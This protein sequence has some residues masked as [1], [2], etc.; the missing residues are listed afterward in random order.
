MAT[1]RVWGRGQ[2]T[3]PAALRKDVGIKPDSQ[4]RVVKAGSALLLT[5]KFSEGDA[6]AAKFEKAMKAKGLSLESLLKDLRRER[7]HAA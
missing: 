6:L 3:L 7:R 4:V 2:I 1:A 5:P